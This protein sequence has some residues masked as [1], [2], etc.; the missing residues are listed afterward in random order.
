MYRALLTFTFVGVLAVPQ[1]ASGQTGL[2]A[3]FASVTTDHSDRSWSHGRAFNVLNSR[4][5]NQPGSIEGLSNR[6]LG[7][8]EAPEAREEI[9][10]SSPP[11]PMSVLLVSTGLLCVFVVRRPKQDELEIDEAQSTSPLGA[12]TI[13]R[14]AAPG[15]TKARSGANA[16]PG[17]LRPGGISPPTRRCRRLIGRT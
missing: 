11:E 2:G 15:T 9:L 16:A 6:T 3:D 1:V 14:N 8:G 5:V 12:R 17:H 7:I 10:A 13:Q 4:S